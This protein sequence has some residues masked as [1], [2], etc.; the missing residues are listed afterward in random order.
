MAGNRAVTFMG[1]YKMEVQDKGYPKLADP[2]GRK[3]EH[4]A[5]LKLITTNIC[6]SDLHIYRGRFAAPSGMQ[7]GH[8][9][10]GEVVEV[11]S[12]VEHIK[13]GDWVSVPF[14]V[15]C[16]TCR[17]CKERHTDVCLRANEDL[18]FCGA[19]GFNLGGWQGGQ[20]DYML[21]PWADF[22]LLK[23]PDKDQALEKIRDLTLLSDILPTGYHGCVEA[24]VT[25]GSTVYIAGAGPVGRC[26]AASAQLLGASCIIVGDD[27][28][29]RLELVKNAG[30]ETVDTANA[31]PVPDQIEQI[32]GRGQRWVDAA[33]DCVGLECHGYGPDGRTQNEEEAVL[34]LLMQ[35]I[36]P[37]GHMGIPGVYTDMDPG[38]PNDTNRQGKM[39]LSFPKAWVKSPH[40]MAGQCPVMRYN[41]DLMMS[42]LWNR[43]PYLTPLLN[44]EVIPLDRATEAYKI[45]DEGAPVKYVIDPHNMTKL[46]AGESERAKRPR[47]AHPAH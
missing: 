3:I 5:I 7:M 26:A 27:N 19:Y 31:T 21:V 34:N 46:A 13:K 29:A 12:H 37:A 15:A 20:A 16:G 44:T 1:P 14:N 24:Q 9:N 11:G 32:I 4:A 10:T 33:V 25:T 6:G 8:E 38:A 43:M 45:F 40:F 47:V 17:N 39:A 30:Y 2:K 41:R 42:I 35:V 23:F 36:K 28:K 18:G 22:Q